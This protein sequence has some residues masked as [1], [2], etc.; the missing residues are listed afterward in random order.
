MLASRQGELLS[1]AG[2]SFASGAGSN[3]SGARN[4]LQNGPAALF[5]YVSGDGDTTNLKIVVTMK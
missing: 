1:V 5:G 3:L 4:I 2:L